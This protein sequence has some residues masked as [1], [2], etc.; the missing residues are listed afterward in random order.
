MNTFSNEFVYNRVVVHKTTRVFPF[1]V[2]YELN[3]LTPMDLIPFPN[4]SHFIHKKGVSSSKFVKKC[5]RG[6]SL[7]YNTKSRDI[8][9]IIIKVRGMWFLKEIGF[10]SIWA[11]IDFQ[12]SILAVMILLGWVIK[13]INNNVYRLELLCEYYV[14]TTLSMCVS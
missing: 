8:L 10:G 14:N 2:V 1:E 11:K 13:K 7:K 6:W 4:P 12:N 9:S 3:S 5:M